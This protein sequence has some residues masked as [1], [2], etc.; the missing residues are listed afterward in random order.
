MPAVRRSSTRA[1]LAA[2]ANISEP[3]PTPAT[4]ETKTK[5]KTPRKRKAATELVKDAQKIPKPDTVND[6]AE[7]A[8]TASASATVDVKDEQE[9]DFVP[10]VLTFDFDDAKEHLIQVDSRFE[11][12]FSKMP[13]KPFEHLEQVHPFRYEA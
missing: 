1:A 9:N 6:K 13:C 11:D 4:E 10:A 2:A 5:T 12:L 8:I 3:V 7:T